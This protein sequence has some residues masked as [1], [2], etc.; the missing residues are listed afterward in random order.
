MAGLQVRFLEC[1]IYKYTNTHEKLLVAVEYAV[2]L[3]LLIA[4][5]TI[6]SW[7]V[8]CRF[9]FWRQ[10]AQ[11]HVQSVV[12]SSP[13]GTDP[14]LASQLHQLAWSS[15]LQRPKAAKPQHQ[16][17]QLV[18]PAGPSATNM[19]VDRPACLQAKLRQYV[20]AHVHWRAQLASAAPLTP[21]D[22]WISL[23]H[24]EQVSLS[25]SSHMLDGLLQPA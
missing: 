2:I 15:L 19:I 18:M 5:H 6:L 3:Q 21:A 16:G 13:S 17:K 4:S 20:Q 7:P 12:C 8:P 24:E 14:R 22:K 9:V 11:Q 25:I 10:V 1:G 23:E